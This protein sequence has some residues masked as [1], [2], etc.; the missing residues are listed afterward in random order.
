[1]RAQPG[2]L[3]LITDVPGL[4]VG[5]AH[6]ARIRTGVTVLMPDQPC[7][8]ACDVRGGAPGT[9]GTEALVPDTIIEVI[10]AIVLSGG[11]IYGLAAADGVTAWLG[12]P[13]RGFRFP[14]L[15]PE[16][17]GAPG[18]PAAI[19]Y[20]L[21]NG[22]DKA[23]GEDPPYRRL[24]REAAEAADRTFALGRAGAGFGASAGQFPGGVGSA[25]IVSSDGFTVGAL[26]AINCFG[27]VVAGD[28]KTFWAAP[29]EIGGEFGGHGSSGLA[30]APDD[31]GPA[32]APAGP[33][34]TTIACIATDAALTRSEARR[35]AIMAQDGLARAIR[36]IHAPF[37]G[38]A[39]FVLA[40]GQ[41][42]VTEF[43]H[44]A[45]ARLGAFA[46]DV[47]ARAVARGVYEAQKQA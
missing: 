5:Q 17:P 19:L 43:R 30:I 16:V 7:V 14:G 8:C 27:S 11:S 44:M 9:A 2:P 36:P 38:D 12:A 23:W 1:M 42:P 25:S 46:A 20:D 4:R 15:G 40:T 21:N 28:G 10:D 39:V 18:V 24:G 35:V 47:L 31:W 3:N 32:K 37:D 41:R 34:N 45:V 33:T 13:G 22:G 26:A 6:D 29:Y